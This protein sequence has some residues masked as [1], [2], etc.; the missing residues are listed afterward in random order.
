M[1]DVEE[2]TTENNEDNVVGSS[3]TSEVDS[4]T[5]APVE[6]AQVETK[7]G[8]ERQRNFRLPLARVKTIMKMDP[9]CHLISQD[10]CIIVTKATVSS[11]KQIQYFEVNFNLTYK[12]VLANNLL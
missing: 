5:T 1:I 3:S 10:A 8:T 4:E 7:V 6:P 12:M 11:I 9:D 2:V